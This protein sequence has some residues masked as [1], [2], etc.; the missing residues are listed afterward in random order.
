[1]RVLVSKS[2]GRRKVN[3]VAVFKKYGFEGI[4]WNQKRR[5]KYLSLVQGPPDLAGPGVADPP[6]RRSMR[7]LRKLA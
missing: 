5:R 7:R 1:M 4:Q 2:S 3:R 6:G